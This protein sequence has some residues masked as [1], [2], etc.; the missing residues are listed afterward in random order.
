MNVSL[1]R[2]TLI[3]VMLA[4]AV[5]QGQQNQKVIKDPAEYN[6]YISAL[7]TSDPTAKAIAME[8]FAQ[9]YPQSTVLTDALEQAMAAYQQAGN[10]VKVL[11][12]ARRILVV[13]PNNIRTLAIVA[14]L[15]RAIAA[16]DDPNAEAALREGCACAQ[17]GLKQL[18]GWPKPEGMTDS[19][20][21]QLR[22]QMGDVFYGAAG[23]CALKEK[24]YAAARS[25]YE[26][27]FRSDPTQLLDVWQLAVSELEMDPIDPQGFWY[28]GK[29][30]DMAKRSN[31]QA[32]VDSM[33]GY[34]QA[35][36]TR[37]YGA[38]EGWNQIVANAAHQNSPSQAP[39]D[40]HQSLQA[41]LSSQHQSALNSQERLAEAAERSGQPR[42]AL[43][44]Y[45]SALQDLPLL[46][47]SDVDQELRRRI[48]RLVLTLNPPPALPEEAR[49]HSAFAAT[50]LKL[51]EKDPS[52]LNKALDES[53]QVLRIAP[54]QPNAYFNAG[55]ILEKL[56][57]YPEAMRCLKL[58]LLAAPNAADADAVQQ[59][60]YSLEY[61]AKQQSAR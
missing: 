61:L 29:A 42:E 5:F 57:R 20:F 1:L 7:N 10:Q 37:N 21:Q 36:Y 41:L 49:R 4:A 56:Q 19:D 2:R 15:D 44:H 40:A 55:L 18:A 60:I 50:A 45:L 3:M 35:K 6:A 54:W 23:F 16:K 13:D 25:F 32:G 39:H 9:Q 28:C 8:T 17:T 26:K 43:Q 24:D 33:A 30:I 22:S 12:T 51:A 53:L 27:A 34:C 46:P 59:K 14:F 11:E 58:Y 48:I 31:N 47:P 52:Q 38:E